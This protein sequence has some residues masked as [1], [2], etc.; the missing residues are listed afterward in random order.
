MKDKTR[1]LGL[2]VLSEAPWGTHLCHFYDTK[3]DLIDTLV[4]YFKAGLENNEFCMWVTSEPLKVDDAKA[5]LG[6]AVEN[7]DDYIERGQIEILDYS[8]WY[9]RSG[10][11]NADE[12]LQGWVEKL[13]QALQR[14]FDGLR[15]SGNTFWLEK[16]DWDYFA[17]YEAAV[18]NVIG[19]YRILAICSYSLGK[20]GSYELIDVVKNHEFAIVKRHGTWELF[21]STER[22]RIKKELLKKQDE[23]NIIFNS[24]PAL[25]WSKNREGKYLS[26]NRTYCETVGLSE[27]KIIN[28]TDYDLYPTDIA[29]QYSKYDQKIINSK[30]PV[31]G[32]EERHLKPSGN[33]G[34]SLTA[35]LP[36]YD[37]K[38]NVVGTIGFALD[39]TERKRAEEALQESE[40]KFREFVEGTDDLVTRV[41]S[42][43]TFTYVNDTSEK[44]LG[45][46]PEEC[47]GLSA[48]DFI[49][50]DDRERTKAAFA[51]WVRERVSS[52]TFENR[53]VSRSGQVYYMQWAINSKFDEDGNLIAINSIARDFTE[54]KL[55]E[56]RLKQY[57]DTQEVLI[58]EVNHRVTNNL[59]AIIG[60]LGMEE[61]H[62]VEEGSTYYLSFLQNLT[63]RIRG[64]SLVHGL[65]SA[66]G[67]QPL[68]LSLLCEKIL[69]SATQGA[70]S[71]NLEI[72]VTPSQ[73]MVSSTHAHHLA[74]VINELA[75]NSIKHRITNRDNININI[76]IEQDGAK[77]TVKFKDN[78]PGFP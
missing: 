7:L 67:W 77:T 43:G 23:L 19:K 51:E 59:S 41:D 35:K 38:G 39:I 48:F 62:A 55:A 4:P 71:K 14:G 73:V 58:R 56:K 10:Q 13:N 25:I 22:R 46:S 15:L 52:I 20:C 68:K 11:F 29:T 49:H 78:G 40:E 8:Q 17:E 53:Q 66:S 33:Y 18:D 65:L 63:A 24:V 74:M 3:E 2:D 44:I 1:K 70:L 64:L 60:M 26:V 36:Y 37:D 6:E 61:E 72:S 28:R 31:S 50:P 27:E 45:L 12:V 9:T 57:A 30:K 47:I 32:I 16:K 69:K 21:E 75:T 5:S 42:N 76:I 34:W 54:L